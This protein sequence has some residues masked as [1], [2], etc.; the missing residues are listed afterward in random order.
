MNNS[1]GGRNADTYDAATHGKAK[2]T[3]S[4]CFICGSTPG[5]VYLTA[6]TWVCDKHSDGTGG[7]YLEGSADD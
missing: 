6:S 3:D 4:Y 1:T 7:H 2:M 5:T